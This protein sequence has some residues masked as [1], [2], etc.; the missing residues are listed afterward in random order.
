MS[1]KQGNCIYPHLGTAI[2][3]SWTEGLTVPVRKEKRNE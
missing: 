2:N 1:G 3:A